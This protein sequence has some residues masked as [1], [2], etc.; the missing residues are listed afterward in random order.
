MT[1]SITRS[2][3]FMSPTMEVGAGIVFF[4]LGAWFLYQA[5]DGRGRD[6]PKILRPFTF[7]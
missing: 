1:N 4:L 6:T 3:H 2:R 5:Y 7:W